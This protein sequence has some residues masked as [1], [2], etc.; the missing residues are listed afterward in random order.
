MKERMAL[1]RRL[2]I[3]RTAIARHHS[4]ETHTQMK[5]VVM[6]APGGLAVLKLETVGL[7]SRSRR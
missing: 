1:V 5:A 3:S 7:P 6:H 2:T 4:T